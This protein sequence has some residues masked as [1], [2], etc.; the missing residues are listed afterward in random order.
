[1]KVNSE[2]LLSFIYH[3]DLE[4]LGSGAQG[5]VFSGKINGTEMVA[6]KK[7][8]EIHELDVKHLTKLEHENIVKFM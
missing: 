4:W 5:A 2:S 8:Q 6:I 7:V 1:M 3:L